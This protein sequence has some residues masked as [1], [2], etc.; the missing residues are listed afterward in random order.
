LILILH[1]IKSLR[2]LHLTEEITYKK[3]HIPT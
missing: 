2:E 3:L 1:N